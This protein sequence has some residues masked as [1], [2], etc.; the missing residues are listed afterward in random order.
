[1]IA[2]GRCLKKEHKIPG[3]NFDRSRLAASDGRGL[4][5]DEAIMSNNMVMTIDL[6]EV[7]KRVRYRL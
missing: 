4:P 5:Q 6:G 1:V 2:D 7:V 3:W